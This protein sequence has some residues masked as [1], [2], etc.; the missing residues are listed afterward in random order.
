M[1]DP[2]LKPED[3]TIPVPV[4]P[5][6]DAR[7]AVPVIRIPEL[8]LVVLVGASGCG[9]STFAR[10]HFLPTEVLSSDFFRAMVRDDETDQS[11][12]T[13]AFD[14]LHFVARRRL[15]AGRIVVVDA[16][17]V[18]PE[19]RKALVALARECHVFAVAIV[20]N[21]PERVCSER[22]RARTDRQVPPHVI[23][24][25]VSQLRRGLRGL[26]REGFRQVYVL[27]SP[28]AV[29]TAALVREPLWN[30]RRADAG[31]FD[32]IGDVHGC[33]D[34]LNALLDLLGYAPGDD[35][36][37][38]HAE[39]RK[40]VFVGDLVDRGPRV[41]EVLKTAMAMVEA[42]SA[43]AVPGNHDVK[44]VKALRGRN[45]QLKHGLQ[46]SLDGLAAES[47][48]FRAK[49]AGFLDKL[50]SHY[51]FDGGRLVVAHA[52]MKEEMQGRSSGAVREF[53]LYGDTTGEAD[54]LGLPVRLDW[55]REY[56]GKAA[57]VYGHTP[58]ARAVWVNG[59]IN[60]DTGC[61]FGGSLTALRWPERELVSVPAAREYAEPARP[62]LP[63]PGE[64]EAIDDGLLELEDVSGK[65][66]VETRL[67]RTVTIREENAAA[68]LEVMTRFA[69]N[70][71]WL[72]Y[73]PPTMSPSET[74]QA[75]GLL[76]HPAEAFAYYRRE[77]VARVVC[78]E[79]HMGSRAVV[80]VCRDEAAARR[81]FGVAGEGIG[82]VYTRTGRR[83]FTDDALEAQV[84][85][86]VASAIG[87]AGLWEELETD[88]AV[89][90]CELMPWS[91]KAQEL[92]RDQYAAVGAAARGALGEAVA[93]LERAA[94]RGAPVAELL[95]RHRERRR[96]VDAYAAAYRRYCW[97][98][99]SM[100]DLRLAPFHLLATEGAVHVGRDHL[101]HL[102]TIGRIRA[103]ADGLLYPTGHRVVALDDAESE[104]E[105]TAWW[106]EMTE[107]GGEGMVV[108][109]LEFVASGRRGLVQPAVKCRGRE[110]LRIIYGPEYTDP[111]NLERLRQRGLGAKR[112][113]ALREFALGIEALERFVRGEPLRRVHECV[114]GVLAMES[115]PVDPRL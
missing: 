39:G 52:G 34:E 11:A 33:A 107:A 101:W 6:R 102:E 95:A 53:A 104:A 43:L 80:V 45:V 30:D 22:N 84:L 61:V 29:E 64:E 36:V 48:E 27:D 23:P 24:Q 110:Y 16:T 14:V 15:R 3:A 71:R 13:D 93:V 94:G 28:Q 26:Q 74:T 92:V 89:L 86:T 59:T 91:A 31:P 57:V 58:V 41:A 17:S 75:P 50:V 54:E 67:H 56:R 82:I 9:K 18:Q 60:I 111:A 2:V 47:E 88:W 10:R 69:A 37:R 81:R 97:P 62:F 77:G 106:E 20:L 19:S 85:A 115:E 78:E 49:V 112:S 46:A 63:L 51:V 72:V 90:D 96:L 73:L 113:L 40:V 12:T 83:F 66:Y 8:S 42:G 38:R 98:V 32:V 99:E 4:E 35:G 105:A 79:K 65:R 7:D 68:A 44:L 103:A 1:T 70:P 109:P 55:A 25:Q 76:E 108:K 114:F 5:R 87:A 100:A 21:L